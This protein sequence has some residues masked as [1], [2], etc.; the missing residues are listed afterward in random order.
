[1]ARSQVSDRQLIGFDPSKLSSCVLWGDVSR[2]LTFGSGTALATWTDQVGGV[3]F[4]QATASKRP[5]YTSQTQGGKAGLVWLTANSKVLVGTSSILS[6]LSAFTICLVI[7]ANGTVSNQVI[8]DNDADAGT[9]QL[10]TNALNVYASAGNYGALAFTDSA[11]AHILTIVFDGSLS[12][13]NNRLKL[14]VDGLQKELAFTGTIPATVGAITTWAIVDITGGGVPYNG[15]TGDI[16]ICNEA[17][18]STNRQNLERFMS[19]KFG[20]SNL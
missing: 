6:S 17:I 8:L 18:S 12:G 1:M 20:I 10:L 2:G 9:I 11:Q 13:N 19:R 5:A 4:T 7:K 15:S 3:A 14:Y 16:V